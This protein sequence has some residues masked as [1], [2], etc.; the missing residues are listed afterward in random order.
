LLADP[1]NYQHGPAE[2][3]IYPV[4]NRPHDEHFPDVAFTSNLDG[5]PIAV[6]THAVDEPENCMLVVIAR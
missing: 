3:H 6:K 2:S 4:T 1:D 5:F